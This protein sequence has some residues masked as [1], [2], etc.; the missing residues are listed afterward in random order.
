MVSSKAQSSGGG[1]RQ[2]VRNVSTKGPMTRRRPPVPTP[3][4]VSLLTA[5]AISAINSTGCREFTEANCL[6]RCSSRA[7]NPGAD[8]V[9]ETPARKTSLNP[10][11]QNRGVA[12]PHPGRSGWRPEAPR[13]LAVGAPVRI[14]KPSPCCRRSSRR[15]AHPSCPNSWLRDCF[16]AGCSPLGF[17]ESPRVK[18]LLVVVALA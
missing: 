10:C 15:S 1:A 17:A 5:F 4:A 9:R 14:A 18:T 12:H 7:G 3:A 8:A 2:R 6:S 11:P 13:P 16:G